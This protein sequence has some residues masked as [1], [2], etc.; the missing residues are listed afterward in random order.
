M[1]GMANS[2]ENNT[3]SKLRQSKKQYISEEK[4]K[5]LFQNELKIL[6]REGCKRK[7]EC[8]EVLTRNPLPA[9]A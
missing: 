3:A 1:V 6:F 4:V 2:T 7:Y 8:D 5:G 9:N